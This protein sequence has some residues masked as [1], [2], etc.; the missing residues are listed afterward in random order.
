M[1][2]IKMYKNFKIFGNPI[3]VSYQLNTSN[4]KIKISS[5]YVTK[6]MNK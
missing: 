3:A 5:G 4:K 6:I 1:Y 2:H